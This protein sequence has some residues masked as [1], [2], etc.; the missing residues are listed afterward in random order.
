M[1]PSRLLPALV[2]VLVGAVLAPGTAPAATP[3]AFFGVN[4]DGP[5]IGSDGGFPDAGRVRGTGTRT[6][7]VAAYWGLMEP[8]QG[9]LDYAGFD[10]VVLDAARNDLGV[11]PVVQG[12]PA[13]AAKF[14]GRPLYTPPPKGT[15]DFARFV[16]RLV[17]RYGPKGSLWAAHPEV[18]R[19]PIRT[20]Q[21]WNEPEIKVYWD[22]Q[23]WS[24]GYAKLLRAAHDALKKADP[25]SVVVA[26]GLTNQS[27]SDLKVLY[28]HGARGAFDVAALHPYTAQVG[29][30]LTLIKRFRAV[31]KA[32]GDRRLPLMITEAGWSSGQGSSTFNYGWETTEAGQ[33]DRVRQLMGLLAKNRRE[34]RLSAAYWYTWMTPAI[35]EADS[36][37]YAGLRRVG[38]GGAPVD[39]PALGAWRETLARL[40]R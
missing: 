1:R 5:A 23:D 33:A 35:G 40:T 3:K 38:D 17:G 15:R 34:F 22:E 11:L 24:P 14:K 9:K 7:R 28:F 29:G 32:V 19:R 6:V 12:T 8:E 26:A 37:K 27:W 25:K 21:I 2:A 4:V 39:K 10:R 20:W 16:T 18:R 36:F 31:M 30:V 13:W